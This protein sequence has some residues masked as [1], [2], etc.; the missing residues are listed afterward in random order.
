MKENARI[1]NLKEEIE[2][3]K[4]NLPIDLK[5]KLEDEESKEKLIELKEM[6]ES[7]WKLRH[8]AKK[9][10]RKSEKVERLD[11]I[12]N[13]EE[14]LNK[15]N[16]IVEELKREEEKAKIEKEKRE[17]EIEKEKK[18]AKANKL[19]KESEKIEKLKKA[20]LLGK[21]WEMLRW[22]THFLKENHEKWE[23]E[24]KERY[25]E[26]RKKIEEWEKAKRLEK[27]EILKRK[28]SEGKVEGKKN[29]VVESPLKENIIWQTWRKRK[30]PE[31]P[32][33][34]GS[35][36]KKPKND[37]PLPENAPPPGQK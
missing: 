6:K 13:L 32:F 34:Q 37:V 2:I 26:S 5:K 3:S 36:Q 27:I 23:E 20:E 16:V 31:S 10:E 12:D 14:K 18:K 9:Y 17:K 4:N 35:D 28:W 25:I 15:I 21:H 1:R 11:E 33:I 24:R 29:A 8:K 7:L 22:L 19:K 30:E